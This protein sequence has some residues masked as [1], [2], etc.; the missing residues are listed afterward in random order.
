MLTAPQPRRRRPRATR[1][2]R[3]E[4]SEYLLQRIEEFKEQ[5]SREELMAI[6]DEAVRE[7]DAGASDQLVLTEVLMLEHVDRVIQRRLN[8][9]SY[10]TWRGRHLRLRR[11]QQ[12]PTHWGLPPD[13]AVAR[14]ARDDALDGPALVVGAG[15]ATAALFLAAHEWDVTFIDADLSAVESLETR[16]AAESLAARIQTLVVRFGL[17]FPEILP[18]LAVIDPTPLGQATRAERTRF[19]EAL[20][21]AT[22][23]GGVHVI[24]GGQNRDGVLPLALEALRTLYGGWQV[25]RSRGPAREV[26]ALKP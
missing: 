13:S 6:A 19:F 17:W 12:E 23:A 8:L 10:R 5:I 21:A 18:T 26:T 2:L 4:Y 11:A 1:S 20:I 15:M 24:T 25:T 14:F 16:S 3:Q 9:P 7:L 22:P